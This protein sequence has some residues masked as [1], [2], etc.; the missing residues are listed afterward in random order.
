MAETTSAPSLQE[1]SDRATPGRLDLQAFDLDCGGVPLIA[2]PDDIPVGGTPTNGLVAIATLLPSECPIDHIGPDPRRAQ[3][4]AAY[5]ARLWTD[6]RA[7]RLIDP[8]TL[9]EAV[10]A[11]RAEGVREGLEQAVVAVGQLLEGPFSSPEEKYQ[12]HVLA[13]QI[14]A[15]IPAPPTTPGGR[16]DGT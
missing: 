9:T 6:H 1:L 12:A 14:R 4:N 8:T 13:G 3:A 2:V 16:T 10:A 15:L 7:G 5:L 11:A